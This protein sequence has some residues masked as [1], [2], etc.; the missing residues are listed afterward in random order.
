[1]KPG[2]ACVSMAEHQHIPDT[3]MRDW[4]GSV[5]PVGRVR[6]TSTLRVTYAGGLE[7]KIGMVSFLTSY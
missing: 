7:K 5:G 4:P 6:P 3:L 1:M 2:K